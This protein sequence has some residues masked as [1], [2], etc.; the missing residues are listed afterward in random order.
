MTQISFKSN[1]NTE[2]KQQTDCLC[3]QSTGICSTT[4]ETP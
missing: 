1:T 3:D 2:N 4:E